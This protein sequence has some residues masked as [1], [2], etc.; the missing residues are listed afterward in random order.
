[1]IIKSAALTAAL[2]TAACAEARD[3]QPLAEPRDAQA[4]AQPAPAAAPTMTATP[5]TIAPLPSAAQRDEALAFTD[6][7]FVLGTW[8]IAEANRPLMRCVQIL[9]VTRTH[10]ATGEVE[11]LS[12]IGNRC[13]FPVRFIGEVGKSDESRTV[14]VAELRVKTLMLPNE[15]YDL[16][17][18]KG[19]NCFRDVELVA[20]ET[21]EN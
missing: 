10:Q 8:K 19:G 3:G 18:V 7:P 12:K 16:P 1:M 6:H 13:S 11:Q 2:L 17:D 9:S 5:A 4:A 15:D 14:C 21:G 20:A